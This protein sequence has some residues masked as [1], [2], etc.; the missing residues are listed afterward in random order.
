MIIEKSNR[1]F[2]DLEGTAWLATVGP[3]TLKRLRKRGIDFEGRMADYI[4]FDEGLNNDRCEILFEFVRDQLSDHGI[5]KEAFNDRV[6][7]RVL[8]FGIAAC[9]LA[10]LEHMRIPPAQRD[11]IAGSLMNLNSST[12]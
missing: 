1:Q 6:N 3:R 5:T 2:V 9:G 11:S 10:L 8:F 7:Q 12:R 4:G